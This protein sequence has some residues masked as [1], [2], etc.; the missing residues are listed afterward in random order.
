MWNTSFNIANNNSKILYLGGVESLS[1]EGAQARNGNAIISNIVGNPYGQIVGYKYK[2]NENG[3]RIYDK[4]GYPIR[5]DKPEVLG[6]GV[7]KVTGGFRNDFTYKDFSLSLLFDYKFGAKIFSGTN[8][9]LYSTG[10]HK[11]TLGGR[12]GGYVGKGV[13]NTGTSDNP[14]WAPNTKAVDAQLYWKRI[15]SENAIDEEFVY[16]AS[17]IKLRELSV[18]YRVPQS[19]IRG[20]FVKALS[21][22]LVGRNLWTLLKHT[23]NIDPE[24]AYNNT[25]GQGL[26]LNGYPPTRSIGF[27]V[28][29]KF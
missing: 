14:V 12:E 11:E 22:S 23:P 26:E 16:D 9:N 5:T 29:V 18:G 25:N 13:V 6:N 15:S 8:L 2:T 17:F 7:Y 24:S 10:L 28:N 19:F 21:L 3:D 27:N 1:I 20:S 4:D